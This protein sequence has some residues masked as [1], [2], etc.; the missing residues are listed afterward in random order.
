MATQDGPIQ[1]KTLLNQRNVGG[2][3]RP[4]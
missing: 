1:T 2:S 4:V 3:E